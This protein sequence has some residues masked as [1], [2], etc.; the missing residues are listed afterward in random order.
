MFT[1]VPQC[2]PTFQLQNTGYYIQNKINK[3]C[4]WIILL[5]V[6]EGLPWSASTLYQPPGREREG[7][8]NLIGETG[9]HEAL[10]GGGGVA[11]IAL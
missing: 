8:V 2:T 9:T 6:L 7:S 3:G 1:D 10:Q 11:L 5:L 4:K